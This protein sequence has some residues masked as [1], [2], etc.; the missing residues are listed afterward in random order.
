MS[1]C[2]IEIVAS[3]KKCITNLY[4]QDTCGRGVSDNIGPMPVLVL[5]VARASR[6]PS[7]GVSS[8]I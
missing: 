4:E 1:D 7:S 2:V 3:K 8:T 6:R 5:V